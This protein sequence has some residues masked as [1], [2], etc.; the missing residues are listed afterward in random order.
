MRTTWDF[1]STERIV[2]GNGAIQQLGEILQRLGAK[3]VLLISDPGIKQ[4]GIVDKVLALLEQA[5]YH[6]VVYDQVIPEPPIDS[7]LECYEFAKSQNTDAVIGL[8]GGSSIDM[9]KIVALLVAHG[10][11]PLDYYGGENQVPG[12]IAPLVAIPTT[13]GTGSEVTSVSVLTDVKNNL[14]VGIS[15]NYLRPTVALLD[16]ELTIGLPSY[17]TA[18]SGIDALSHAIEAYTAK[19][20]SFI[21]AEGQILFQGSIPISDALAYRAIELIAKN[22][23]LAVQQGT[24]LEA[25]SNMLLGSLLAGMAFSNAGTAAA[26]ALAYPIGGLVKSPHGEVT[27]LLLPYV[28]E[29]NTAVETE[30]MVKILKAFD[31]NADGLSRKE[32]ALAASKAVFNLLE[33][34]GLPTHLSDIGIKEEDVAEIAEKTLQIDR[35]VRNNPRVPTLHGLEELLR[36]AL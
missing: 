30:K 17:V 18:C 20:F 4:A 13:A 15:D 14:K 19:P 28:M 8:G 22:L 35:L 29:F 16:P 36:K 10:G 26:H 2:F 5:S 6:A 27:G 1:Y 21:Q 32:A 23:P 31:I 12:P 33:T 7:A 34:I 25:R 24:N 11:H 9:A 3:N